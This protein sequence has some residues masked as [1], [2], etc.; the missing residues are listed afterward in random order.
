MVREA[1]EIRG[2]LREKV[3]GKCGGRRKSEVS[4]ER[5]E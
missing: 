1:T 2:E 3:G 4:V 5:I